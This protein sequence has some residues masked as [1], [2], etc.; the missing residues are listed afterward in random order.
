MTVGR[1]VGRLRWSNGDGQA[2]MERDNATVFSW[3]SGVYCVPFKMFQALDADYDL[4]HGR[5]QHGPT[6]SSNNTINNHASHLIQSA[7]SCF[8]TTLT[9]HSHYQNE[10]ESDQQPWSKL[11]G[12]GGAVVLLL[13]QAAVTGAQVKCDPMQLSACATVIL[14]SLPPSPECC[15]KLKE[16]R[17]CLCGYMKGPSLKPYIYSPGARK[18]TNSCGVAINC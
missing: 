3:C 4:L 11:G 9:H 1:C 12:G 2:T 17:P 6:L 14:Q 13:Q 18:V 16:Q 15:T 7:L 5:Q 8:L 10:Q